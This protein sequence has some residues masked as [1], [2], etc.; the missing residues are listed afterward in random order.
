MTSVASPKAP[1]HNSPNRTPAKLLDLAARILAVAR[2]TIELFDDSKTKAHKT[3]QAD[4]EIGEKGCLRVKKPPKVEVNKEAAGG[5]GKKKSKKP[6]LGR[7]DDQADY[8]EDEP[9]WEEDAD[10]LITT[11]KAPTR[12][13]EQDYENEVVGGKMPGGLDRAGEAM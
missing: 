2:R 5:T 1:T 6:A 13:L 4:M 11:P 12:A 7:D 10:G 9:E 8:L 3:L